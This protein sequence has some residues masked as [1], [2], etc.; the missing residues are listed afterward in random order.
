MREK[1]FEDVEIPE[2]EADAHKL[3]EPI[4]ATVFLKT[5]MSLPPD[6]V[7]GVLHVG[8]KMVLGGGSK[9][10]K[11][12]TLL[13]LAVS[14]AAGEPW[15]GIN[16]K[17]APALFLNFEIPDAFFQKRIAEVRTAK[18]VTL[19][20][21]QL[22][23]M[24][25]RGRGT[26]A[27]TLIPALIE[28]LKKHPAKLVVV[29]PTY[30]LYGNRNENAASDMGELMN[31]L[32]R[33]A[34]EAECAVAFGA[35]FAKGSAAGKEVID[36]VSGSGVFARDPDSILT[37]TPHEQENAR[38]VEMVLRNHPQQEPFVVRWE[39][40]LM[41]R[42]QALDPAKLKKPKGGR[43]AIYSAKDILDVLPAEGLKK[44]QWQKLAA[45]ETGI[46]SGK[47]Y[48]LA[49]KLEADGKVFHSKIDGLWKPQS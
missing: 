17:Q 14:V 2:P 26:D 32:E 21:G 46:S 47:F 30:K 6:L 24:N 36:R 34:V 19:E 41:V 37:L 28:V 45:E 8:G 16:T 13:D 40:P 43:E 9:S 27:T 4:D 31:L 35:H 15:L 49:K 1:L 44:T 11:T 18:A 3:P 12:W 39:Y 7:D 33:V 20:P 5:E 42:D 29:D 48:E 23:I 38:T 25:L 10:F 22:Q